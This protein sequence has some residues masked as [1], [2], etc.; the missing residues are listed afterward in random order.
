MCGYCIHSGYVL[1]ISKSE[2]F[3]DRFIEGDAGFARLLSARY[4]QESKNLAVAIN[5]IWQI[6]KCSWFY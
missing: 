4:L 5:K 6:T 3:I 2:D 1:P